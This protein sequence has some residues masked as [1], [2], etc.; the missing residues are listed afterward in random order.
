MKFKQEALYTMK[1]VQKT[2]PINSQNQA[3]WEKCGYTH[4]GESFLIGA[5]C[6]K[7]DNYKEFEG[8]KTENGS[9]DFDYTKI[10]AFCS[11]CGAEMSNAEQPK[12]KNHLEKAFE[13]CADQ[14]KQEAVKTVTETL[15]VPVK[16]RPHYAYNTDINGKEGK[17]KIVFETDDWNGYRQ[18]EEYIRENFID[19][20]REKASSPIRNAFETIDEEFEANKNYGIMK[21]LKSRGYYGDYNLSEEMAIKA[22]IVFLCE[23]CDDK[24]KQIDDLGN[25]VGELTAKI[26]RYVTD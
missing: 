3:I 8:R 11:V 25:R 20:K 13:E 9:I 22:L 16:K 7:C 23:I 1:E 14:L 2:A 15:K 24:Q 21:Y 17:Y 19:R 6:S 10:D 12:K 18:L 26:D 5:A 4:K